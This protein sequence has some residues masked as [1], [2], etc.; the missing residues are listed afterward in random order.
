LQRRRHTTK[1]ELLA[2]IMSHTFTRLTFL[3]LSGAFASIAHADGDEVLAPPSIVVAEGTSLAIAGVGLHEASAADIAI[4]IPAGNTV[5]QVLLYWQG[6]ALSEAE[7]GPLDTIQ[8]N[9]STQVVGNRIGGPRYFFTDSTGQAWASTYRA[10]IT[11]LALVA[12]GPNTINVGNLNFGNGNN[13]AGIIVILDDGSP[14]GYLDIRDGQDLAFI[15][16]AAPLD[17]TTPMTYTFPPASVDRPGSL[18]MHF[19]SV[20]TGVGGATAGRPTI[21]D[22]SIDGVL[23]QSLNDELNAVN[24]GEWDALT[25]AV[26]IPAGATS[27]TV[28]PRSADSFLGPFAGQL[29]ASLAWVASSFYIPPPPPFVG[30]DEGCTPGYWKQPQHLDSWLATGYATTDLFNDVFNV[31]TFPS[32]TLLEVLSQGGGGVRALGRHAVAALLNAS[33]PEV[34]YELTEVEVLLSVNEELTNGTEA[35]IE[36][37]KNDLDLFNNEGCPLD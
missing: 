23:V 6:F 30:G 10:D 3:A 22:I 29:P 26:T 17:A 35:S 4:A 8:V 21:I 18:A 2:I 19:A 24:G 31:T 36:L 15:N 37:L 32:K 5:R 14:H 34:D 1:R 13:G 33:S 20:A 28:R 27:L 12:T 11:S 25:H 7:Q 16:F 9:G